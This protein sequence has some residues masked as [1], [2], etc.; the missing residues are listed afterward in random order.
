MIKKMSNVLAIFI[1]DG[2]GNIYKDQ[3]IVFYVKKG[4]S[5]YVSKTL[6][7]GYDH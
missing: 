6:Y 2:G 4:D 5:L 7:Y 3:L 1:F